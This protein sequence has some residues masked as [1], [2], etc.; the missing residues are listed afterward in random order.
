[1]SSDPTTRRRAVGL[2]RASQAAGFSA[3]FLLPNFYELTTTGRARFHTAVPLTTV[4]W[5]NIFDIVIVA[6][7][8]ALIFT[9]LRRL[10]FW[11]AIKIVIAV[12][13]PLLLIRRNA[14]V[15][16][17]EFGTRLQI[18]SGVTAIALLFSIYFLA[19]RVHDA[20]MRVGSALLTGLGIFAILSCAQ[21]LR[22]AAWRPPIQQIQN[23]LPP[24]PT[25]VHPRVV[26]IVFDELAYRQ[27]FGPRPSDLHLPNFDSLRDQ[28]TL[29]TDVLPAGTRTAIVLPSLL[30]GKQVTR[31]AYTWSNRVLLIT[32]SDPAWQA[33]NGQQTIFAIAHNNGW[34]TAV[35]GWFNPY[36]SMMRGQLDQCYWTGWDG[37]DGPM[38]PTASIVTN[39]F[40][41]LKILAEKFVNPRKAKR[42][43]D[44]F[45]IANHH[46]SFE[47]LRARS[48]DTLENSDADFILLHLPI[49]HPPGIYSRHTGQFVAAPGASYIDNLVLADRTLGELLRVLQSS[50][51]WPET[52]VIV[53]G[54][55]SWRVS[56]WRDT[57]LQWSPEDQKIS[58][59]V[60]DSR[61]AILVHHAEQSS[62]STISSRFQLIQL[63][64]LLALQFQ[65]K[66]R[67]AVLR[68]IRR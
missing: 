58:G 23:N 33:F 38:S 3:L 20:V 65:R 12:A 43:S 68:Q 15:L 66:R 45:L 37:M 19:P 24:R 41:P 29:Y 22:C 40:L 57:L 52:T 11:S 53:N 5:A 34:R 50:P 13:I 49:P 47:D 62:P 2:K 51:R 28:S 7:V 31:V 18:A 16:P 67:V 21:L 55:H 64:V 9:I 59:G 1:M 30:L 54:D 10:P 61:P 44:A 17:F 27:T 8:A 14:V 63:N 36:C 39:T 56:L 6:L 46:A 60:F 48:L 4:A 25:N 32:A 35:V 42:D 26:W